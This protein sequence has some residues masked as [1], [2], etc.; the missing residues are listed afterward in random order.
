VTDSPVFVDGRFLTS[1]GFHDLGLASGLDILCIALIQ[2]A[3][4]SAQHIHRLLD[5]R[6]TGLPDQLT[7][8]PG[9][10]AGLIVVHKRV[11]GAVHRLRRLAMPAT[12]G[13]VETS[14]GQEDA[15]TF[16]FEA[17]EKLRTVEHVLRDVIAC[18]LLVSRQAWALRASP[19][20]DGLREYAA[21]LADVVEPVEHDRRLGPEIDA[22]AALV[23]MGAFQ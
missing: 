21:E 17:A 11:V 8:S 20:A 15:M 14:L 2:A 12:V 4:L 13:I 16:G 10:Q 5:T 7:G 1:G 22:L 19:P 9:P 6:F 3:E 18:E 23:S